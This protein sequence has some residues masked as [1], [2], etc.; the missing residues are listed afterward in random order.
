MREF[1][2]LKRFSL[3]CMAAETDLVPGCQEEL[4]ELTLVHGMTSAA[5]SHRNRAMHELPADYGFLVV[6]EKT[7]VT[8][9]GAK[10]E[11]V[12]RL[13]RIVT[14]YAFPLLHRSMNEFLGGQLLVAVVT[15]F[16]NV[17]NGFELMF[18]DLLMAKC[19]VPHRDRPVNEL[20][21]SHF[22]MAFLSDAGFLRLGC[23]IL[24]KRPATVG[25]RQKGQRNG[26]KGYQNNKFLL[27]SVTSS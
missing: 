1:F 15:E 13:M 23:I 5:A 22:D 3:I 25:M 9:G 14:A 16:P 8:A 2:I 7:K 27:H 26:R 10:L 24:R 21:L 4:R 20:L 12:W 6:T 18:F 19:T 11:L 17:S